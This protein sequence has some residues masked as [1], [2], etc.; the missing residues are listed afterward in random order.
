M[1]G[2]EA[3]AARSGDLTATGHTGLLN[4]YLRGS[5]ATTSRRAC[6]PTS[7]RFGS[8]TS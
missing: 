7:W 8:T 6:S 4:E 3:F 1:D 2:L 5:S